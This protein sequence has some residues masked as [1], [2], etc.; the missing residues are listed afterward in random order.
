MGH[1]YDQ[2]S[3]SYNSLHKEEQLKKLAIIKKHLK[4]SPE[5]KLLDVGC[6]T[7]ISSDFPCTV[8]GIDPSED[9]LKLNPYKEKILAKAESLPFEDNQFDI[10][11]S[12][13]AIH[14]FDDIEKGLREMR[15]VGKE[16]FVFSVLKRSA[17]IKD[18]KEL[19]NRY[20]KVSFIIEEEKDII[21][22]VD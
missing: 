13:T 1:Y 17:K 22:F 18:I 3:G 14:N 8:I 9:L 21:F 12:V 7:G 10:V 15:R 19:I 20:F 5:D 4:V 16:R 6:G 11:I 2:I